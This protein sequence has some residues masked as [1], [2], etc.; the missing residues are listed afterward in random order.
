MAETLN[1]SLREFENV[2]VVELSGSLTNNTIDTFRSLINRISDKE[3]AIVNLENVTLVTSGG[4]HA[5]VDVSQ[6]A[7]RKDKRVIILWAGEDVVRMSEI[8]DVYSL[9]I[10]AESLE[11]GVRKIRYYT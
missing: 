4:L 3:S 9:L 5:L 1:Y 11:E 6:V 7:K 8:I 2:K 10:F